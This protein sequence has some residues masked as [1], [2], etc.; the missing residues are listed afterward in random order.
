MTSLDGILEQID[1]LVP[2]PAIASQIMIKSDDPESSLAEMADL[3]I[4]S[5]W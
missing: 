4:V 5:W 2:L 3:I 1:L